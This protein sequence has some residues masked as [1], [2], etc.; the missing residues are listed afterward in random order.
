M[1]ME[2]F[3]IVAALFYLV[4]AMLWSIDLKPNTSHFALESELT[5]RSKQLLERES[6][7]YEIKS[8]LNFLRSI[9]YLLFVIFMLLGLK[10]WSL[11]VIAVLTALSER[12]A[13][14][15][16]S[17][18]NRSYFKIE[19]QLLVFVKSHLR[20]IRL[21]IGSRKY[22]FDYPAKS[23]AELISYIKRSKD[24]LDPKDQKLINGIFSFDNH[25][26]IEVMTKLADMKTVEYKELLGPLMLNELSKTG[27]YSFPVIRNNNL[28]Q[29]VGLL[30]IND[31]L[32]LKSKRS[33][34]VETAMNREVKAINSSTKLRQAY[35]VFIRTKQPILIVKDDNQAVIGLVTLTDILKT[36]I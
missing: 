17:W 26:V 33:I 25:T 28:D 24:I 4:W 9:C 3:L 12:L 7:Y 21:L 23:K 14:L 30:N 32:T 18:S 15:V 13:N 20:I 5:P 34:T 11:V 10:W 27:H 2:W 35:E 31:L 36:I 22:Q 8:I 19:K 6:Y 1:F 29:I 16:R